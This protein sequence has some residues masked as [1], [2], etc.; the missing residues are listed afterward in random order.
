M[1]NPYPAPAARISLFRFYTT[2]IGIL[3]LI[4]VLF[5]FY[6]AGYRISDWK[7]AKVGG[8]EINTSLAGS[9]IFIDDHLEKITAS[10]DETVT[11]KKLLPGEHTVVVSKDQYWPWKKRVTIRPE[12]TVSV[13]SFTL[14]VNLQGTLVA[15][16]DVRY[17][18]I[19]GIMREQSFPQKGSPKISADKNVVIWAESEEEELPVIKAVWAG[20]PN[21]KP[22]IFANAPRG[23]ITVL[24]LK[25]PLRNLDFYKDRN[26]VYLFASKNGIF[27]IE[28]D[29][30]A[31]QNFQPLYIGKENP[32]FWKATPETLYLKE[33]G[34]LI[35][36]HF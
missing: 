2:L 3:V 30:S 13:S 27:A 19:V 36:L 35:E 21:E 33:A 23:E 24:T 7:I 17:A 5:L 20:N 26:D 6:R 28:L 22:D 31:P 9:R 4:S 15:K 34:A 8:L 25:E 11:F 14:P 12:Q 1:K 32:Q 18:N 16:D 29:A 10:N